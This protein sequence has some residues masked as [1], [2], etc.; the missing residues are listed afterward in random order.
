MHVPTAC[1][2]AAYAITG[3]FFGGFSDKLP[4]SEVERIK[5]WVKP[6]TR[7]PYAAE[8][9]KDISYKTSQKTVGWSFEIPRE[10]NVTAQEVKDVNRAMFKNNPKRMAKLLYLS[11]IEESG[12]KAVYVE[13]YKAVTCDF[14]D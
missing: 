6:E 10:N 11:L 13:M 7:L 5:K 2:A 8:V 4:P 14:P 1:K 12:V 9:W 3:Y